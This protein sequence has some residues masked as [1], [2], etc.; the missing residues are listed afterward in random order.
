MLLLLLLLLLLLGAWLLRAYDSV[1]QQPQDA[2]MTQ[3]IFNTVPLV[4]LM[5]LM[6]F[7]ATLRAEPANTIADAEALKQQA[8]E[9]NRDLLVLEE[10]LLYPASSQ[11]A[12]YLSLDVGEYF[13]LDA[14]KLKVD[15]KLV[16]SELYT[17]AQVDALWRGGIQK[18]YLGNINSGS[19]QI[20]AFFTGLGPQGQ[21]YK[22]AASATL[23]KT[24]A[25]LVVE[26]RITDSTRKLQPVFA[27]KQWA[28]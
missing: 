23:D 15:G 16:A 9:L 1:R 14:V 5:G 10:E 22:R 17:P 3:R 21:P 18:L 25:P 20:S 19:H 11:V 13:A 6:A 27:I 26:L 8:L 4:L 7:A 24:T 28:L 2:L 12:V